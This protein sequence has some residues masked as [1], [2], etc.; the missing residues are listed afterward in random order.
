MA[1]LRARQPLAPAPLALG[2][3]V[4]E[5][6]GRGG[7]WEALHGVTTWT[8]AHQGLAGCCHCREPNCQT[9]RPALAPLPSQGQRL[10]GSA[11]FV[12]E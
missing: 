2:Q 3:S 11:S 1:I 8:S 10:G 6:S 12:R 9:Q 4:Y 7:G 5:P